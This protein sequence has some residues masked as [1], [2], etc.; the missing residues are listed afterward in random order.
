MGTVRRFLNCG[1]ANEPIWVRLYVHPNGDD[2][3]AMIVADDMAPPLP[4][5]LKGLSVFGDTPA[6]ATEL[7]LRYLGRCTEQN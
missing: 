3:A 4:G 1:P 5:E 7:A 6:E 2:W